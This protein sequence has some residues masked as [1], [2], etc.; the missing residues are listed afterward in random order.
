MIAVEERDSIA[1]LTLDRGGARNAIPVSG[2]DALA[3]RVA[4]IAQSDVS[5]VLLRSAMPGVFSAG[6]DLTEFPSLIAE[7]VA[8][9]RFRTAMHRAIEGL[10]GL[11][12]PVVAA[13]D[14]GCFGAAVAL[15]LACDIVVAGGEAVFATTPAKLGIGYP[16]SDVARLRARV[17]AGQAATMLFTGGRID[18]T[19]AAR[20]GLAHHLAP[21][22]E[23]AAHDLTRAIAANAP[24]AVRLLKRILRHPDDADHDRAFDAMFG[25]EAFAARLNAFLS[26]AR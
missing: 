4:A 25:E 18:A 11:P 2:W 10:A 17:G 21:H 1:I 15:T 13:V 14:G 6:A 8:R 16:A 3:D 19:E 26:G 20:I 5:A 7:P 9:A 23:G 24:E 12:M 22:A